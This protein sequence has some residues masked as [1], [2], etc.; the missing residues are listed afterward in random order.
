MS[1]ISLQTPSPSPSWSHILHQPPAL[2]RRIAEF[3]PF[4]KLTPEVA[5]FL[6]LLPSRHL[7]A[8][9]IKGYKILY[10]AVIFIPLGLF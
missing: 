9:I 5:L 2:Y 4:V 7:N 6:Y 1:L 10:Y 3:A 8:S